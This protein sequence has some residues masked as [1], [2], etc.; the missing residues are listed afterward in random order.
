MA[1]LPSSSRAQSSNTRV[2]ADGLTVWQNLLVSDIAERDIG[3]TIAAE[4]GK[5]YAVYL[6]RP[7]DRLFR[8]LDGGNPAAAHG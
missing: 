1:P 2:N 7:L 3:M 4:A 6:N 5:A 8:A